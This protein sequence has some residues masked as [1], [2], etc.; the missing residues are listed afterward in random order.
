[1]ADELVTYGID[2]RVGIISL[3]RPDKLNAISADL[4]RA[5]VG[6][7][8]E[9]D[10]DPATSVVVLRAEGRAF[11]S[12]YDI[13]PNPAR[14]AR[15]GNAL[16]WHQSL[17]DDVTLEMTPWDMRKPVIASVQ[18]HC[19]GGGCE[20]AMMCDL[21]I[22]AAD[23]VF[24]EPEIR[25]SNVGPALIMPFVI[26]Y[27]R[28]RELLYLGDTIDAPTALQYGMVNRVVPRAEL[29]A[30]TMKF[31]RRLALVSP[32]ALAGTKLAINRGADAAGFRNA[33]RAG[34]DVV[35]PLYAA[36]TDVG[37]KFDEIREKDGLGAALRWRAAQ[38]AE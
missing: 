29:Q 36:T 35:A 7:F 1:M 16:A 22:A 34:L 28:A 23:A 14:A 4:K 2:G 12:G 11:C 38:F 20:L 37:T 31:A 19:L 21:T 18:G 13:G 8:H 26:G 3:N 25:F 30:A 6:R 5:L 24:G 33:I 9:A 27:K 17:T 15:R 10:R 32:E